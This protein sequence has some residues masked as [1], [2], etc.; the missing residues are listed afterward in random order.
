MQTEIKAIIVEDEK[1]ASEALEDLIRLVSSRVKVI[2]SVESVSEAVESIQEHRPSLIFLDIQLGDEKSFKILENLPDRSCEV[3]FV[4]AYNTH[5]IEAFQFSAVDYL[6]KP[7]NPDRLEEAIERA[8]RRIDE[9]K[10]VSKLDVLVENLTSVDRK[11]KKIVLSTLDFIH[12]V[13]IQTI[14]KC[15]SSIN[16]TI[17]HLVGGKEILVSKTLK[18]YDEQL[19]PHGFFRTHKSWLINMSFVR[20]YNRKDGGGAMLDDGTEVPVSIAKKEEF[21]DALKSFF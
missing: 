17:F 11:P 1:R 5:A 15:H 3:I 13:D 2:S 4:T 6:L 10:E 19:S 18:E 8:A 14:V 7:I 20:G 16:Y 21:M 9:G 12:F